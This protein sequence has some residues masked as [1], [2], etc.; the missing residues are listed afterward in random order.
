[1]QYTIREAS[2]SDSPEILALTIDGIR[3]WAAPV[4]S[5][6]QLWMDEVCTMEYVKKR[7]L[8]HEYHVFVAESAGEIIGTIY[9][10]TTN[11]NNPYFGGLYCKYKKQ[12]IG[13]AL[14]NHMFSY[15]RSMECENV[16]CEVYADNPPSMLL[17]E[18][19]G[20]KH[21][22]SLNYDDVPYLVYTFTLNSN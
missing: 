13:T 21:T 3:E 9:L 11:K 6:V 2:Q 12:G 16:E 5:R 15:A 7:S 8:N 14:M 17:M 18:K 10:N 4:M 22:S 1:M 19:L 20:A